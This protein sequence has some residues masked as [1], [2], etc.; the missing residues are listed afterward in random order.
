M[1][2]MVVFIVF[3][4]L[5]R[6]MDRTGRYSILLH[7]IIKGWESDMVR[8]VGMGEEPFL[9]PNSLSRTEDLER[10][11]KIATNTREDLER[12]AKVCTNGR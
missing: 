8:V 10:K 5:S 3:A 4:D 12:E 6:A 7:S 9:D 11:A 2:I 1:N